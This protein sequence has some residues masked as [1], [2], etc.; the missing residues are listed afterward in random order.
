[1]RNLTPTDVQ[2]SLNILLVKYCAVRQSF[3]ELC[4]NYSQ[5]LKTEA[6]ETCK[7]AMEREF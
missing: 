2:E 5:N 4:L 6:T 3:S 1:M 7:T